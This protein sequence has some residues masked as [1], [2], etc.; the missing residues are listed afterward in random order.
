[1]AFSSMWADL[2]GVSFRQDWIDARGTRTRYLACGNAGRPAL[3]FLHGT[4]GHA[5][6]Y[7]RNLGPHGE[8]FRTYSID[9]LGHGWTDKP[10]R[11]M[12][13][14]AYVDH[15]VD[16]LDALK[17]E[18]A[19]ISGESLG[20]WVAARFALSHPDR[21]DRLVLNTTGGSAARPEVMTKI[22]ELSSRA[23]N[24]PSWD[25]IR[26]R[27]E[28]LMADPSRVT[29]DL[30]AT[31]QAIYA[32][33]GFKDA[34]QRALVL[35][36]MDVR[37]KNLLSDHEWERILAETLVVWTTHDPTNPVSEGARIASLIPKATFAV[38]EGCGHWP[39]FEDPGVFNAMHIDFLN[40]ADISRFMKQ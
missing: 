28:W 34:M 9:M 7:I 40:G 29:D 2:R 36:D 11:V 19:H 25:F 38:M 39:Q 22:K 24:D 26:A 1:M 37:R 4:G 27:L 18:R 32:A 13:I 23:A 6:A 30:V 5:E 15:L 20:G 8:F 12:D 16:V 33:P 17:I 14:S 10:D 31:R 21:V 3:V 35:Q